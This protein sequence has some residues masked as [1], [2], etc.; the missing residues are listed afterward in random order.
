ML[1]SSNNRN[2]PGRGSNAHSVK[3][4]RWVLP[5]S[6][7]LAACMA[8]NPQETSAMTDIHCEIRTKP[9]GKTLEL[10]GVVWTDGRQMTGDYSFVV[11]SQGPG[12]SSNVAQKGL[13]SVNPR[14]E[15]V[16]GT[17]IV[18]ARAGNRFLARLT[19]TSEGE[20]CTAEA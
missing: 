3:Q 6:L 14:E 5:A 11:N 13:F 12:G 17:V 1:E 10:V 19:I 15:A 16:I 20:I 4:T 18:N 2:A 8:V 9:V 7:L